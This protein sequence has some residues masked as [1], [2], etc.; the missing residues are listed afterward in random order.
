[1]IAHVDMDAFFAAVEQ[2]DNPA[3]QGRPV[4][5]GAD[6]QDG[7][8]R[9]VVAACSYE[10][11]KF[12]IHSAM[13][14]SFAYGRCPHAVFLRGDMHKYAAVSRQIFKILERFSPDIEPISIDEGFID[15][16]GSYQL[17]GSPEETCKKI[18]ATIKQETGLTASIG[19]A[20]NKMTAK[21]AS[22]LKKPDGLVI[23]KPQDLLQFL[24]TLPVEK[25]W[26]VGKNTLSNLKKFGIQK[27]GDLA[28]RDKKQ[29]MDLFGKHGVHLW[30][31]ARGIDPRP[32]RPSE[33]VKSIG[34]ERTYIKDETD[35][36]KIES[37]LMFL[38]EKVSR[39]LRKANYKGRTITL[40]IRFSDFKTFTRAGSLHQPTNF[41]ED[42]YRIVL[43]KAHEFPLGKNPVR[44]I[45]VAVSNLAIEEKQPNLFAAEDSDSGKKEKLHTAL[46]EIKDR[47]G[48]T[49]IKYRK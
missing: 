3:L 40:K 18:K 45:G 15:L 47:F 22:D 38:S 44:L 28:K 32:V 39:R 31:L 34:N 49:A 29:M 5:V 26:G 21:I 19:L 25:L 35:V 13:P 7:K 20:P 30:K 24:H 33:S 1:M 2:R 11:R 4:I 17:F 9:G 43:Q 42:I 8:G 37:T 10:A 16:T 27:V 48:E 12:G 41:V 23:V 14:I 36:K 46:D 6:P